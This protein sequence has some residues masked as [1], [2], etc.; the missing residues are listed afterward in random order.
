MPFAEVDERVDKS[1]TSSNQAK[2]LKEWKQ[3]NQFKAEFII[4]VQNRRRWVPFGFQTA[5]FF[6]LFLKKKEKGKTSNNKM[7]LCILVGAF[8]VCD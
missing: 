4:R 1:I 5:N 8:K 7:R 6:H 2:V 3:L